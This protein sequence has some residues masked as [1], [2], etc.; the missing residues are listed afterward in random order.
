MLEKVKLIKIGNSQGFRLPKRVISKYGFGNHI[1]LEE[2]PEGILLRTSKK[3]KL[4]WEDTYKAMAE[5]EEE[6]DVWQDAD[7][8]AETHL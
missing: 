6:W 5:T 2:M 8:D 4:S 7:I 1:V 3:N